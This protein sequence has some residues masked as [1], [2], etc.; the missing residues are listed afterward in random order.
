[1][2][3]ELGF[4]AETASIGEA[5]HAQNLGQKPGNIIFDSPAKTPA[6]IHHALVTGMHLNID[7]FEELMVV[8]KVRESLPV[9]SSKSDIGLRI[10]PLVGA[11][12]I[13]ALSV[14]TED[15]KFGISGHRKPELLAAFAKYPWLNTVHVHV[16]SGNMGVEILTE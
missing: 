11:G 8:A 7:N 15:S 2:A 3:R 5:L 1:M 6:E 4:G 14:S 16:G 12:A 10:N 9:G 13:A